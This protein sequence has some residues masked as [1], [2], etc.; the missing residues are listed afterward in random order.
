M[1]RE[2]LKGLGLEDDAIEKVMAEHGKTVQAVTGERDS[3]KEQLTQ[4]DKQLTELKESTKDNADL[5]EKLKTLEAERDQAKTDAESKLAA[6]QK[7]FAI[8]IALRDAGARNSKTVRALLDEEKLEMKDGKLAGLDDQLTGIKKDNDYLFQGEADPAKPHI[9]TG[10][11]PDPKA[12]DGNS[13]A[14]A[15]GIKE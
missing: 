10:G 12:P 14:A 6:A 15:L 3:L 5:Q 9:T 8:D 4:T 7:G 1:N 13:M 2:F 11:N